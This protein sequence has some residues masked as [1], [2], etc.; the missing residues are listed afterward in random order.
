MSPAE[1]YRPL[2]HIGYHR[3]GTS[4]LQGFLFRDPEAGFHSPW[5]YVD[6]SARLA[7][8]NALDFDPD[9]AG[10]FFAPQMSIARERGLVPV[11]S[12]ERLSGSPHA[13]GYDS[14]A[15]AD[16]LF[17]TFPDARILIGIREQKSILVSVYKLYVRQG[18]AGSLR[19]YLHPPPA[20]R[21]RVPQ[22][23]FEHF[24]YHR[25]I[26]HYQHRFGAER[27]LVLPFERLRE[28]A[29]GFV[30]AIATFAGTKAPEQLPAARQNVALSAFSIA[31]KRRLNLFLLRDTTNPAG[32]IEDP[33]VHRRVRRAFESFDRFVPSFL[34]APLE[35]RLRA[36]VERDVGDR[37][38][39]SNRATSELIGVDL[40]RYGYDV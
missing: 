6:A 39:E 12:V 35:R 34:N 10:S 3:T 8:G 22:F 5:R 38:R 26:A 28:D 15:I 1:G 16:R 23:D 37:Y 13:G 4:W 36:R 40:A 7:L 29:R 11:I 30:D 2:V 14:R 31:L 17:E 24:A 20:G 25:L 19:G 33:R 21:G 27:V 32:W 9:T 18:G